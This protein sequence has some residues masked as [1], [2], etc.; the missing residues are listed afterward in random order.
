M[1][2]K[3]FS[4]DIIE[5]IRS[6]IS[7]SLGNEVF[8]VG[9][10]DSSGL[11]SEIEVLARGNE[12]SVPAIIDSA[13]SGQ[14]V[15]HNH[16]SGN[17]TPSEQDIY[18]ASIFGNNGV[19]FAI[20]DNEVSGVYVVVE[21]FREKK[22][23]KIDLNEAKGYLI[24][25]GPISDLLENNYEFREEQILVLNRVLSS[26]NNN[27][28]E[29]IEAGTG[30]GKTF[31]YLIPSILWALKN[32]EKVVVSTNTIN[33]QEQLIHKDIPLMAKVIPE[34]FRYSLVK[35]MKNYVCL[36]R[37]E[38]LADNQMDIFEDGHIT[39]I[40]DLINWSRTTD[41][42]SLSDLNFTPNEDVWDKISAES[43][44]CIRTKCPYYSRCFFFKDRREIAASQLVVVNHHMFFSDL[45]IKIATQ[46]NQ[47][48]ILPSY[49]RV[50]FDEAHN[51]VDVAT[52][53]FSSRLSKYGLMRAIRRLKSKNKK[54]E[55][56]GLIYYCTSVSAKL[57]R[58]Q[59]HEDVNLLKILSKTE[60]V[61]SPRVDQVEILVDETFDMLGEFATFANDSANQR[62]N[63]FNIRITKYLI[64]TQ[65]W[66]IA[67]LKFND[68]K[69]YIRGL[70]DEIKKLVSL[71]EKDEDED[72][73]LKILVEFR[74]IVY[75][76]EY[77]AEVVD[78]FF[79][80]NDDLKVRWIEIKER[81]KNLSYSIGISPIDVSD[82]LQ[83]NMYKNL[84]SAV[85]TSA[86]LAIDKNFEFSK[87]QMGLQKLDEVNEVLV[88]SPFNFKEQVTLCIPIDV[89]EHEDK[90]YAQKMS[91]YLKE[92]FLL[93]NGNA[94]IL[95]TSYKML[96]TVYSA[97]K[98]ELLDGINLLVQGMEPRNQLIDRFK[99]T[100]NSVLFA[101]DSFW[102]G[103][104]VPG[105]SLRLLVIMKLPFKVPTDPIF[106][107]K[108]EYL[109]S[110]NINPFLEYSVPLAV[111]KFKQGFG[112][113]IRSKKEKGVA[114]VLDKRVVT[115][116]YGK[117]FINSLPDCNVIHGKFRGLLGKIEEFL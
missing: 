84:D 71:F 74:S 53:H 107:A 105:D 115:K 26:F 4:K 48:G 7:A 39:E 36:L 5:S 116:H 56:K 62:V 106:A 96:N 6:E 3:L 47:F 117:Y 37:A 34:K 98:Q 52:S 70:I 94:L 100:K 89:P 65:Q 112:R 93:T 29:L 20:V 60:E 81:N 30:T 1:I 64:N 91:L 51:I 23:L 38:T 10:F 21:P 66:A 95:F 69:K 50:I 9:D 72:F 114:V 27:S 42:G 12:F 88:E 11:C 44:S 76:L 99:R 43:D 78:E 104:D 8:F 18:L 68:L 46:D 111:I 73:V 57:S 97:I 49:R 67:K 16:P 13:R 80:E 45:A 40:N 41:Q 63:N 102:E 110:Q 2:E 59:K 31:S 86:T 14:I 55:V 33:L 85:I 109:K 17:L 32:N 83:E 54:G 87:E 24:P 77:Y 90:N 35:G 75:K 19:S 58:K 22:N 103:I 113:L 92:L 79:S 108:S 101:T 28:I 25:G 61:F 82:Y 15:L